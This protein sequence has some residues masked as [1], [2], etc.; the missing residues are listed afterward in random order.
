MKTTHEKL[1]AIKAELERSLMYN[2]YIKNIGKVFFMSGNSGCVLRDV[3]YYRS[4]AHEYEFELLDIDSQYFAGSKE[5][6]EALQRAFG[7][8]V[9]PSEY[10]S[11]A[12]NR[13]E[14]YIWDSGVPA[15]S[16]TPLDFNEAVEAIFC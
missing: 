9:Y 5:H 6:A 12:V 3:V 14:L 1:Q 7:G 13:R 2:G 10:C 4:K 8:K 11:Y 16:K 15:G